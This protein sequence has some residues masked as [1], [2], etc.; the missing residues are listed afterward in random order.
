MP[1]VVDPQ[2]ILHIF[3]KKSQLSDNICS[4]QLMQCASKV[5]RDF[6]DA[7]LIFSLD[8]IAARRAK[9]SIPVYRET[10]RDQPADQVKIDHY[11]N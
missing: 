7:M 6:P 1:N 9:P 8:P 5:K 3:R 2:M 11:I 4:M 10:L